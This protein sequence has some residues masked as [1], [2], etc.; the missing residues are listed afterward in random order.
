M[1]THVY[2]DDDHHLQTIANLLGAASKIVTLAGAGISTNAGIPDF[3]SKN[4]TYSR[5][6]RHLFRSSV[7][8]DT[9][10]RHHFY[11]NIAKMRQAAMDA[12]PTKTHRF[13]RNLHDAGKLVRHYTQNIDCLEEKTGLS[14]D[15]RTGLESVECVL[16]HGSLHRFR[17]S[18]CLA[19][20]RQEVDRE[21]ETDLDP[22]SPCPACTKISNDRKA[23]GKRAS[24]I[25][26]LRLDIV[27]YD[28]LDPRAESISAVVRYDQSLRLD[29]FLIMGTSLA[30]DGVRR[31]L[32]DF[33]EVIHERRVGKVVF[34]NLTKPAK[35]WDNVIDY[36]IKWDCDAW[37]GD[38]MERQPALDPSAATFG[39]PL[40]L[41]LLENAQHP[42]R[43][44]AGTSADDAILISSDDESDDDLDE[45]RSD[46]SFKSLDGLLQNA[47]NKVKSGRVTGTGIK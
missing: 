20:F 13:I 29:V 27:L 33:A 2:P 42:S 9:E 15:A 41:P 37:V 19:T 46:T 12:D 7:L 31:L 34:V 3:R 21:M 39:V 47:R 22:E 23:R 28:E 43:G 1:I 25:G 36:W 5:G 35:S 26:R 32:R 16:L 18:Y 45:G 14:T 10:S 40:H 24:A 8:V 17:C 4:G 44:G 11:E 38:L 6:Y 30:T